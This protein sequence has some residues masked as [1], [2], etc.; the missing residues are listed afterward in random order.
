MWHSYLM[1]GSMVST[2]TN[3]PPERNLAMPKIYT[4]KQDIL[5]EITD[6]IESGG[7]ATADEFDLDQIVDDCFEYVPAKQGFVQITT[8]E[9]FWESV[10]ANALPDTDS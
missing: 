7:A 10:E 3:A 5:N 4:T 6:A 1:C 8:T 9:E 2:R